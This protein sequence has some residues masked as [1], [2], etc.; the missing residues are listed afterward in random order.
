[1]EPSQ[2]TRTGA[3]PEFKKSVLLYIE[4]LKEEQG[5]A[6]ELTELRKHKKRL[7]DEITG[8]MRSHDMDDATIPDTATISRTTKRRLDTL[9]RSAVETWLAGLLG[10]DGRASEEVG[11]LYDAR[12]VTEVEELMVSQ[13]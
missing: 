7:R 6:K 8:H 10:E 2:S 13:A 4:V 12:G 5:R 3:D 11:K 1:M 9:K